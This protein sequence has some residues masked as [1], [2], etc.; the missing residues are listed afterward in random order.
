MIYRK[1]NYRFLGC[2]RPLLIK[3]VHFFNHFRSYMIQLYIQCQRLHLT[4]QGCRTKRLLLD[5]GWKIRIIN[6]RVELSLHDLIIHTW[7]QYSNLSVSL[8]TRWW[9][10]DRVNY[11]VDVTWRLLKIYGCVLFLYEHGLGN[12]DKLLSI[13]R[14]VEL[15]SLWK[16]NVI[17]G[18]LR[19]NI[20]PFAD[21][22]VVW[23]C[24]I[25]RKEWSWEIISRY[26][27]AFFL[28]CHN[29]YI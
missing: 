10:E 15:P 2:A 1:A 19:L 21:W 23:G 18:S 26:R 17:F 22:S 8:K 20:W 9:L 6:Y 24:I 25:V 7:I 4:D 16:I 5:Q 3:L 11:N 13:K 27:S 28:I 14:F 29:K 12:F